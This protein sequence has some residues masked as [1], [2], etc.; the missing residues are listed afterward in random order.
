MS[1]QKSFLRAKH[2]WM[3]ELERRV[4][5]AYRESQVRAAEAATAWAEGQRAVERATAAKQGLEA[6]KVR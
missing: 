5:S 6:A 3:A 1:S 2:A 4:E